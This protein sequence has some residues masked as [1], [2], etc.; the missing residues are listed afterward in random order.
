MAS[1]TM[2]DAVVVRSEVLA[3]AY[4]AG[5][6]RLPP[7]ECFAPRTVH[8]MPTRRANREA[9]GRSRQSERTRYRALRAAYG[10]R[11]KRQGVKQKHTES[12]L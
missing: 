12:M 5:G 3:A 2:R 1:V 7:V 8:E 11:R 10:R 4:S 6:R 9:S